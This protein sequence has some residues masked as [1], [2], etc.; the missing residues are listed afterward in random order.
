MPD[1][2]E[3]NNRFM[4]SVDKQYPHEWLFGINITHS[5][6]NETYVMIHLFKWSIAIGYMFDYE[7][8]KP[9]EE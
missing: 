5:W 7:G 8:W 3:F 2:N 9:E 4:I 6:A 1:K